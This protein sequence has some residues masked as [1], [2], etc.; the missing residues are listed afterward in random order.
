M[1]PRPIRFPDLDISLKQRLAG[2]VVIIAL[3]VIFIPLLLD[4][5]GM[6]EYRRLKMNMPERPEY[7]FPVVVPE[8]PMPPAPERTA[9]APDGEPAQTRTS[10]GASAHGQRSRTRTAATA[11]AS[12]PKPIPTAKPARRIKP[13]FVVQLA[14]FEK[15]DNARTLVEKL[16]KAG[17]ESFIE[18]HRLAGRRLYRVKVGPMLR[19]EDAKRTLARL[20]RKFHLK[21][22][23]QNWHPADAQ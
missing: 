9:K 23:I 8:K 18:T 10:S 12:K 21:G 22:S 2:A 14:S 4:G 19:R 3:G 13:A 6:E 5:A 11:P 17:F 20:E 1:A 7:E 15:R 16:R